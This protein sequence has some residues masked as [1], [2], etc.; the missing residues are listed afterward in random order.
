MI[1]SVRG[2]KLIFSIDTETCSVSW[3]GEGLPTRSVKDSDFFRVFLDNGVEREI[4]VF[5]RMQ[6]G[7]VTQADDGSLLISYEYL[8]DEEKDLDK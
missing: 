5:S 3:S 2:G 1:Y 8:T 6:R 4:A 7:S